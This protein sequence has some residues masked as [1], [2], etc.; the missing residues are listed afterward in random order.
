M[1]QKIMKLKNW[2]IKSNQAWDRIKEPNRGIYFILIVIICFS[3]GEFLF[4]NSGIIILLII[5]AC[6]RIPYF[7]IMEREK[8]DGKK[9]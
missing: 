1:K 9:T 7:I 6:Y 5:A 3:I 8:K 4:P 2:L